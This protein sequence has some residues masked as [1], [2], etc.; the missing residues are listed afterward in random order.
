MGEPKRESLCGLAQE[1]NGVSL[2]FAVLDGQVH[3]AGPADDG[4]IEVALAPLAI[5][6]PQLGQ[7]LDVDV[8]ETEVVVPEG[9]L[10]PG[11]PV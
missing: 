9:S 4:D 1:R 5:V 11:R 10:A 7:V 3:G 6:S 8:N 2:R